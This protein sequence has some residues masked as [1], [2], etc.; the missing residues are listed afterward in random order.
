VSFE[1]GYDDAWNVL[2]SERS[3]KLNSQSV[4]PTESEHVPQ[5]LPWLETWQ[6]R[7]QRPNL[8]P[9]VPPAAELSISEQSAAVAAEPR[10]R[11]K[12]TMHIGMDLR[13]Q[14]L[15]QSQPGA[16][17]GPWTL[18]ELEESEDEQ[19]NSNEKLF[20]MEKEIT[21]K[22]EQLHVADSSPPESESNEPLRF[23]YTVLHDQD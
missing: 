13:S 14:F 2:V 22:I 1:E 11:E 7:M 17:A 15:A 16:L 21:A 8:T 20:F 9:S 4:H 23:G 5:V 12:M 10:R 3:K 6:D 19:D 18:A